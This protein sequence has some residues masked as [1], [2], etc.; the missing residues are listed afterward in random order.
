MVSDSNSL[1]SAGENDLRYFGI[2]GAIN[3][4]AVSGNFNFAGYRITGLGEPIGDSDAA[5]RFMVVT[6]LGTKMDT[7]ERTNYIRTNGTSTV[8]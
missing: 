3:D 8:L 1:L 2:N 4:L 6:G 5:T 7:S